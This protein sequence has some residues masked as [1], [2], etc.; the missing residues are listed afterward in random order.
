MR[1]TA[2]QHYDSVWNL[3]SEVEKAFT[4]PKR[5]NHRD[6]HPT[7]DVS[8]SETEFTLSMDLPGVPESAVTIETDQGRL[9]IAGE[10]PGR[11]HFDRSFTLPTGVDDDAIQA[12][13]ECGV[14]AITIPK[15]VAAKPRTIEINAPVRAETH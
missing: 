11:G 10:R 13:L 5:D 1:Q 7:I 6:F 9:R 12:K 2:V 3:L 14:L 8:E 15:V 4:L